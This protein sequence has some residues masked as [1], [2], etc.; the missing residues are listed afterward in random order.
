EKW[1]FN[2]WSRSYCIVF[3]GGVTIETIKDY[4]EN[5]DKA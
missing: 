4:I 2:F 1:R 3:S 5:Q